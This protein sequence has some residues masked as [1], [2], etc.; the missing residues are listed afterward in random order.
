[1]PATHSNSEEA[2]LFPERSDRGRV[3][4][5]SNSGDLERWRKGRLRPATSCT[6]LETPPASVSTRS[7]G[8]D[9]GETRSPPARCV[10]P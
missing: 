2:H 7:P 3:K 8:S 6:V 4:N 9:S 10:S 5:I 1:M